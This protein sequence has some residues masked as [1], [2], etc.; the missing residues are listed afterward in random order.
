MEHHDFLHRLAQSNDRRIV[1]LV[2]D[3]VGDLA[4]VDQPQDAARARPRRPT[5]TPWRRAR[6]SAASCRSRPA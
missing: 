3:G 4:T 5:S 2:L 6:R 1:L